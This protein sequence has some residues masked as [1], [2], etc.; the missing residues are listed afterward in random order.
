MKTRFWLQSFLPGV[1]L[2]LLAFFAGTHSH[3]VLGMFGFLCFF[4]MG[5]TVIVEGWKKR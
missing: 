2:L 4:V 1:L 3:V 5:V